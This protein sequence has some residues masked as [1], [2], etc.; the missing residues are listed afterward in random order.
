MLLFSI[1]VNKVLSF[2]ELHEKKPKRKI[3]KIN[4]KKSISKNKKRPLQK[5]PLK[6]NYQTISSRNS[7]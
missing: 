3:K 6:I 2:F 5:W 1:K 4:F 7:V